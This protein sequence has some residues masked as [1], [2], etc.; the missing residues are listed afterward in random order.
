MH[1][2][3]VCGFYTPQGGGIRVYIEQKL[4]LAEELGHDVTILAPGESNFERELSPR[5]RLVTLEAP[6]WVID[7][8]YFAFTR[9]SPV[10][11]ELDR[12][13]PDVVEASSPWLSAEYV[14]RWK[15]PVP[16]AL[17]MHSEPLSAHAYRIFEDFASPA[18]IDAGF[19]WFWERLRRYGSG[20]DA[21]ICASSD[22]ARRMREGGVDS[23]HTIPM[24]VQPGLFSPAR[25]DEQL[26]AHLLESCGLGPDA[27]LLVTAGRLSIEKR[28]PML[29]E[30]VALA[31]R[32]RPIGLVILGAGKSFPRIVKAIGGNP[33]IRIFNPI[34]D[35][36]RFAS[37]LASSDALLHGCEA[38]T[39]GM[40]A[41]EAAASGLPVIA[42]DRGGAADF[43]TV[44]P[45]V[46]YAA[47][48]KADVVR[49]I[50]TLPSR[51]SAPTKP[52]VA[53]TIV[54]HFQD[55]YAL[56]ERLVSERSR[57]AA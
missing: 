12:R 14:S 53:R 10:L 48:D 3:D 26:R 43:A 37:I 5:A 29:V 27:T 56:Y 45:S 39:F 33:H 22:L 31:G 23:V 47:G 30:A 57:A 15:K 7:R 21:V 38:E 46:T 41:A 16:K 17:I 9:T 2:L 13:R 49:A 44:A 11:E 34:S 6:R 19:N 1:V 35:R 36:E 40:T 55:L 52:P 54:E 50:L 32:E 25:R 24:G 42:P 18:T 4:A 51:Y 28:V 8:K 20:F